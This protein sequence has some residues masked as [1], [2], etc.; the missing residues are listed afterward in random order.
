VGVQVNVQDAQAL[1]EQGAIGQFRI[2][3]HAVA[4]AD[5]LQRLINAP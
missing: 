1:D 2:E 5:L 3:L 4:P